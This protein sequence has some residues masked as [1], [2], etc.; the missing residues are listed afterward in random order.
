MQRGRGPVRKDG[1]RTA[2]QDRGH[3]VAFAGQQLA[4]D[5]RVNALV[6]A[7]EPVSGES[8]MDQLLREPRL[9]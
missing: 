4:R 3:P 7:V 5:Q 2:S 6:D 9:S 8:V 1:A